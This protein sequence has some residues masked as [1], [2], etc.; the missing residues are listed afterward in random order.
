MQSLQIG[1]VQGFLTRLFGEDRM[2]LREE[3]DLGDP[4]EQLLSS[5]MET[6][7]PTPPPSRGSRTPSPPQDPSDSTSAPPKV[8]TPPPINK[9]SRQTA[10]KSTGG[11]VPRKVSTTLITRKVTPARPLPPTPT[12][13]FLKVYIPDLMDKLGIAVGCSNKGEETKLR[14]LL[15]TAQA[16]LNELVQRRSPPIIEIEH[17]KQEDL[18]VRL[19]VI[20]NMVVTRTFLEAFEPWFTL[21]EDVLEC[22]KHMGTLD[23]LIPKFRDFSVSI[24]TEELATAQASMHFMDRVSKTVTPLRKPEGYPSFSDEDESENIEVTVKNA[25][26][27]PTPPMLDS[28]TEYIPDI[29][30][31]MYHFR[32]SG[33]KTRLDKHKI[34]LGQALSELQEILKCDSAGEPDQTKE[35]QGKIVGFNTSGR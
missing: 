7:N 28:L 23:Y 20:N 1:E 21:R 5:S 3:M 4:N 25:R 26:A 14:G 10:R 17:T 18:K 16:A 8:P 9:E 27:P 34:Y 15:K 22:R 11:K 35:K 19:K 13:E 12:E 6:G 2:N 32:R 33:E 24:A 31:R 29:L 30:R